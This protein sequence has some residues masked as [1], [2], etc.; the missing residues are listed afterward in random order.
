MAA[1]LQQL[2]SVKRL[3]ED[4]VPGSENLLSFDDGGVVDVADAFWVFEECCCDGCLTL[5]SYET[6]QVVSKLFVAVCVA[7][8]VAQIGSKCSNLI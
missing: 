2:Q 6:E 5:D 1:T 7:V 4:E 8:A 3:V